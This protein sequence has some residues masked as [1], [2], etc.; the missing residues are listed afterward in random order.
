[1]KTQQHKFKM[2]DSE[3]PKGKGSPTRYYTQDDKSDGLNQNG[4]RGEHSDYSQ[5]Q[6]KT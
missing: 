1:M 6:N 3:Y 2:K 4:Y 5:Q